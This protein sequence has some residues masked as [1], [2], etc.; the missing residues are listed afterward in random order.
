[1]LRKLA[2]V[3]TVFLGCGGGGDRP[4]EIHDLPGVSSARLW[5]FAPDD[6]WVGGNRLM[7][8][9]GST[10]TE[11]PTPVTGWV[12]DFWGVAPDNLWAVVSSS[13]DAVIHWDGTS[14]T[15]QY[16]VAG[17]H[18][19]LHAVWG[20]SSSD[21]WVAGDANGPGLAIHWDGLAWTQHALGDRRDVRDLWGSGPADVWAI[22]ETFFDEP[23]IS[24]WDG[25]TWT[26]FAPDVTGHSRFGAGWGASPNDV[27]F[28]DDS[29]TW[30]YFDGT[31][32]SEARLHGA[33][34][35]WGFASDDIWAVG[36]PAGNS[37]EAHL[38]RFDGATWTDTP[39]PVGTGDIHTIHGSSADELWLGGQDRVLR[40]DR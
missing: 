36:S 18:D 37:D 4:Y 23:G 27:W 16:E 5:V 28:V 11:I 3:A 14:W 26:G 1:M 15:K 32:T 39:L 38:F 30:T 21:V 24:H 22:G 8:F 10:W 6:V 33:S 40:L 7:H 31:W 34:T 29:G 19:A 35:I 17:E 9:D 2:V 20:S 12:A 13:P 25:T